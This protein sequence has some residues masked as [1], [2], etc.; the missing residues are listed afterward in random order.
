M[1]MGLGRCHLEK[2]CKGNEWL[3]RHTSDD[4]MDLDVVCSIYVLEGFQRSNYAFGM[5]ART[6]AFLRFAT[7]R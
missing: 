7:I 4:S 2:D 6:F 1:K 5:V 3:A